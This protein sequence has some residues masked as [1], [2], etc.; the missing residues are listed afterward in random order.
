M[1][2]E[3]LLALRVELAMEYLADKQLDI[4][5]LAWCNAEVEKCGWQV[6]DNEFVFAQILFEVV[7]TW[8]DLGSYML[9]FQEQLSQSWAVIVAH[10]E[11]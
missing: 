10:M 5:A 9:N 11:S 4:Q 3:G 6:E 1:F 8:F 7:S 2:A